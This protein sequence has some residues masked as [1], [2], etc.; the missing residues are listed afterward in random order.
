M[1]PFGALGAKQ[2]NKQ[3]TNS[4]YN[5]LTYF[6]SQKSIHPSMVLCVK[7]FLSSRLVKVSH[8]KLFHLGCTCSGVGLHRHLKP[9]AYYVFTKKTLLPKCYFSH[10][11]RT[12][13]T[14]DPSNYFFSCSFHFLQINWKKTSRQKCLPDRQGL[15]EAFLAFFCL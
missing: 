14:V 9:I 13:W 15:S 2:K 8:F 1:C 11:S 3:I 7:I 5:D 6:K 4:D 12:I 10:C